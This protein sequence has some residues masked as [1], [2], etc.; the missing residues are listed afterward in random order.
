ML[1][2]ICQN[3]AATT[4]VKQ[5]ING[6]TSEYQVCLECAA[7]QSTDI[8]HGVG[9]HTDNIFGGLFTLPFIREP[10]NLDICSGCGKTFSEIVQSGILGCPTCYLEFF[11]RL[12]PSIQRIHGKTS[13]VGKIAVSGSRELHVKRELTRLKDELTKALA[14]QEYERCAEIRDQIKELE[15]EE[16]E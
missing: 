5:I 14:L 11:D 9:I 12:Q 15:A 6:S 16:N 10:G 13:H 2:Q 8:F 4:Y 1:C 7:K 3:K